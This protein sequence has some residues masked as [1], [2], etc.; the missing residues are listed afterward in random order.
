MSLFALAPLVLSAAALPSLR[1]GAEP[2][3]SHWALVSRTS[4]GDCDL[5][6]TGNGQ[7]YLFTVNGMEAGS[8]AHYRVSNGD[9]QPIDWRFTSDSSG[10]F[11]RY[12]M[13]FRWHRRGGTVTVSVT[14]ESCA[15]SS[16]FQWRPWGAN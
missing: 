11:S 6:V 5:T 8:P 10:S 3:D 4:D 1:P 13:P 16:S 12:Y 9:M 2:I 15:M 7:I 14:G